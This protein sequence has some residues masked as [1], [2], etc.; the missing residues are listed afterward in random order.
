MSEQA[1]LEQ[2]E[3][4]GYCSL[5]KPHLES[6][7]YT[8]L[9]VVI[10][11]I[12]TMRHFDPETIRLRLRDDQDQARWVML[13][14]ESSCSKVRQ[15]CPGYIILRDRIKK[16]VHHF[17]FGGSLETVSVE[18]ERFFLLRSPAPILEVTHPV[19][20]ISDQLAIEVEAML[21]RFR[22]GWGINDQGFDCR[23]AHIDPMQF[24]QACLQTLLTHYQQHR[25]LRALR[26]EFYQA[27]SKE[28]E[29][30][31]RSGQGCAAHLTLEE[32]FAPGPNP[33]TPPG[34]MP[35]V[36]RVAPVAGEA[37]STSQPRLDGFSGLVGV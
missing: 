23:L 31:V 16:P 10:R 12:P 9:F 4:W 33:T 26:R 18:D 21:A 6:P 8:G 36:S 27:L 22:A 1:F 2:L 19:D 5:P 3:D 24:Y 14:F 29:W 11:K 34:K 15:V 32:L 30:L 35:E 28:K 17:A 20:D 13:N 7:G 37:L 25:T